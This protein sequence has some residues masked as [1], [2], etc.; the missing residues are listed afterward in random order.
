MKKISLFIGIILSINL[1]A[2]DFSDGPYGSEYFDTA[3][4][5]TVEDLNAVPIGDINYDTI[6][7]IQDVIII[8]NLVLHNDYSDLADV[9][10]D[11]N[12]NV[13]DIIEVVNRILN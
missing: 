13:L 5:F 12:V 11:S 10:N 2:L 3:G 9:N 8:V 6:V 4:P 7:N 1:Y